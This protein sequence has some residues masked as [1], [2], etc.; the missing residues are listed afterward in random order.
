[1]IVKP[2]IKIFVLLL[3]LSCGTRQ[4]QQI[5]GDEKQYTDR[6]IEALAKDCKF[7][8]K[9]TNK[10]LFKLDPSQIITLVETS[11]SQ[12]DFLVALLSRT[13]CFDGYSS[14]QIIKIFGD[15]M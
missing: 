14:E 12:N 4:V 11:F 2:L 8:R 10:G 13:D 7:V 9:K 15:A 6:E 1:M 3:L 5:A